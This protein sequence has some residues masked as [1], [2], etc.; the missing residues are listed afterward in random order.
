MGRTLRDL[1]CTVQQTT[2]AVSP[3]KNNLKELL[4]KKKKTFWL[5]HEEE[6]WLTKQLHGGNW[7]GNRNIKMGRDND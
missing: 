6:M 2:S 5:E 3:K 1:F 7:P 4:S